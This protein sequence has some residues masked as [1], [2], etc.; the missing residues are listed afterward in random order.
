M[1]K[2]LC[3]KSLQS[4]LTLCDPMDCGP[5]GS[6]VH[7][8]LQARTLERVAISSSRGSSRPKDRTQLSY[9][10]CAGRRALYHQ[11]H[12]GRWWCLQAVS[13]CPVKHL[14]YDWFSLGLLLCQVPGAPGLPSAD[15]FSSTCVAS[16]HTRLPLLSHLSVRVP[17]PQCLCSSA[18]SFASSLRGF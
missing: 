6:S 18:P 8:I 10:S 1:T 3:A 9:V 13:T 2:S 12:L 11:H 5:L 17:A 15:S 16:G 4:C 7:G 14:G